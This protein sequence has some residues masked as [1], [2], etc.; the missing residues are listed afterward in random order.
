MLAAWDDGWG[1]PLEVEEDPAAEIWFD[2]E[3]QQNQGCRY[4]SQFGLCWTCSVCGESAMSKI[5]AGQR[6]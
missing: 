1:G 3:V 6:I 2:Y 5:T 4:G